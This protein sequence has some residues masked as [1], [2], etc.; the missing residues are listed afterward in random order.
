MLILE[1][2]Q[3]GYGILIE[4]FTD[5]NILVEFDE[6]KKRHV[7]IEGLFSEVDKQLRNPRTYTKPVFMREENKFQN[8]IKAKNAWMEG[9]HPSSMRINMD[10]VAGLVSEL[11][12]ESNKLYGKALLTETPMGNIAKALAEVGTLGVSSRGSGSVKR[13]I[14]QPDYQ[15]KTWDIVL[16]PSVADS[17][18][19]LVREQSEL[20]LQA[21]ADE[22]LLEE[23]LKEMKSGNKK[24]D[25]DKYIV[26]EF[27]RILGK[28]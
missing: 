23:F 27:K 5:T 25:V 16:E 24:K 2:N 14:V 21:G 9:E 26:S 12:W 10:R 22:Q 28:L 6:N 1:G 20:M 7:Y 13:G 8:K 4:E 15:L 18:M 3:E 19:S 17:V 11:K